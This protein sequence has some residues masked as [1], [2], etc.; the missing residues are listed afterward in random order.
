MNLAVARTATVV[1]VSLALVGCAGGPGAAP[2]SELPSAVLPTRSP[3]PSPGAVGYLRP[4][5]G[6][7][8][9]TMAPD[10]ESRVAGAFPQGMATSYAVREVVMAN[11]QTKLRLVILWLSDE[12]F[13]RQVLDPETGLGGPT[14]PEKTSVRGVTAFLH[15]DV[16]PNFLVWQQGRVLALV[17]G[18]DRSAMEE[19]GGRLIDANR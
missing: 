5:S 1:V 2:I 15:T 13:G 16:T 11:Y 6:V 14:R 18:N 4:L 12:S 9:S 7:T 3:S 17:Y 19:L 8:Y 10:V